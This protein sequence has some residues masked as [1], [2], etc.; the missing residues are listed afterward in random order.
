MEDIAIV[1][2]FVVAYALVSRRLSTTV[3]TGPMVFVAFGVLVGPDVLGIVD[4]R[5]ENEL[6]EVLAE[7]TLVLVLFNEAALMHWSL[8]WSNRQIPVRLL[9]IGLPL[10][11][12][13]GMAFAALLFTG[14]DVWQAALIGAILAPTDAALGQAVVTNERVPVRIRE[15]LSVEGGL[16]DGIAAPLVTMFIAASGVAGA[17]ESG[18]FWILYMVEQ[19]GFGLLFGVGAGLIGAVLIGRASSSAWM[20]QTFLEIA[21]AAV[22]ILAFASADL[23]DGNGFIAAFV[24]GITFGNVTRDLRTHMF[25]FSEQSSQLLML[26]TFAI[27]GGVFVADAMGEITWQIALYGVLSLAVIRPLAVAVALTGTH[28]RPATVAFLGWFGPRGLAS[29]VF[30]LLV[31]E[32]EGVPGQDQISLIAT[33]TVL[34]SVFAHGLTAQPGAKSYARHAESIPDEEEAPELDEVERMFRSASRFVTGS[35]HRPRTRP[36]GDT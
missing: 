25:D 12:I 20:S 3:I 28:F 15:A 30:A 4:L 29:I 16:N 14:L 18:G 5:V 22:A 32:T 17:A 7:T 24:A 10:T 9:G 31:I 2:A 11:I 36:S 19:I 34:L 13:F 35:Q 8:F 26:L 33:W 6:L 23:V 1:A 27:F 21:I